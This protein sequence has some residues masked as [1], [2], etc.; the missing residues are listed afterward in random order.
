MDEKEKRKKTDDQESSK[1]MKQSTLDSAFNQTITIKMSYKKLLD[2]CVYLTTLDGRAFLAVH[3][4]G[5][6]M[7]I[8]PILEALGPGHA[9]NRDIV[10]EAAV[11]KAEEVRDMI[12]QET[13][14]K[15]VSVKAD[16]TSLY[17]RSFLGLNIQFMGCR[18]NETRLQLRTLFVKEIHVSH[19]GENLKNIII[20]E[21]AK[22]NISQRKIYTIS[23]D[24][25]ANFVKMV[26]LILPPDANEEALALYSEENYFSSEGEEESDEE[27]NDYE[28]DKGENLNLDSTSGIGKKKKTELT[29]AEI[30][31]MNNMMKAI[32]EASELLGISNGIRCCS[33]TQQLAINESLENEKVFIINKVRTAVKKLRTQD[34]HRARKISKIKKKPII[35]NVTRW[36]STYNMIDRFIIFKDLCKK[37]EIEHIELKFSEE[38]WKE[39]IEIRDT[40]KPSYIATKKFQ[41]EQL[42][43]TE[44][45]TIW[46]TC[47]CETEVFGNSLAQ[48]IVK[49]MEV[50]EAV[51]FNN[52]PFLAAIYLD[53]RYQ[54]LLVEDQKMRAKLH[55]Q[56]IWEKLN[57][58]DD[59]PAETENSD[60]LKDSST[61]EASKSKVLSPAEVAMKKIEEKKKKEDD[62]LIITKINNFDKQERQP[63]DTDVLKF[64]EAKKNTDPQLFSLAMVV[65]A[66]P[67]TQV[68]VE[69][70]FSHLKFILNPLRS[71]LKS[72]IID[73]ILMLRKYFE[74]ERNTGSRKNKKK[75]T[76]L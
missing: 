47:K 46:F 48:A 51:L 24:N 28:E 35:D 11:K 36:G 61:G 29:A 42:T 31:N 10:Q 43:L 13:K 55:L 39:I 53:P 56:D 7:I 1:K 30:E 34:L 73:D 67:A 37:K 50:R 6:R 3:D 9:I 32:E 64:W 14:G 8:D 69:R 44:C 74:N 21:L 60:S 25:G 41:D 23:A 65:F 17:L 40:L 68:S 59:G 76:T 4:I 33:H 66:V 18:L 26:E 71:C 15:L 62:A 16:C 2:A 75:K 20:E 12:K 27:S 70:L 58:K 72:K 52:L 49:C 19:T 38:Q 22:F 45:Y 54:F 63:L 57:E 5:F